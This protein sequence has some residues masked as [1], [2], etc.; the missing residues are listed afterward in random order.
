VR[1]FAIEVV[2]LAREKS[3]VRDRAQDCAF[4]AVINSYYKFYFHYHASFLKIV[5]RQALARPACIP[6]LS[7]DAVRE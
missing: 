1:A 7:Q 6:F 4:M 3:L 5:A 2:A